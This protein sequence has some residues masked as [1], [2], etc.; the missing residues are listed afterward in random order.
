MQHVLV[1]AGSGTSL[2]F[3][4]PSMDELWNATV[5]DLRDGGAELLAM[6]RY[7]IA[8]GLHDLEDLLSRCDAHLQLQPDA[9]Q[10]S[11]FRTAA[12]DKILGLCRA[13]G[14]GHDLVP[15]KQLLRRMARRRGRDARLRL[16]TTNYDTCF[17]Q[18]AGELGLV[19]IDGFSF[20]YPRRFDPRHFDYDI[21]QRR[22]SGGD[23]TPFLPGVF[24]YFKLHGSVDWSVADEGIRMDPLVDATKACLIYPAAAKFQMSFQ[25]PHLELMAQ[26]L[27]SL[28]E[29]GTCV[30]IVGFGF[31]DEHLTAPLLAA[32]GTN[33]HLRTI[34]VSRGVEGRLTAPKTPF[35][36]RLRRLVDSDHDI[37]L[38]A[39]D[40][41]TFVRHIPDLQALTPAERLQR[42]VRA[43][44]ND[45]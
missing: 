27:S 31:N 23:A 14:V 17:E 11:N 12:L 38:L 13:A 2:G 25:Q 37:A 43:A 16:F 22:A 1:L 42:A 45:T 26:Y 6:V 30:V 15:H 3:G 34:I 24:Q 18:A 40:F 9:V 44:S 19:A 32:I 29:P 7:D 39:T 10:V 33:P 28:R 8:G 41:E 35:W 36:K 5:G 4:G 21:V 20:T